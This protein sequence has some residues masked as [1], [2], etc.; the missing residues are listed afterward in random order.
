MFYEL[1]RKND[2]IM[3]LD[4]SETGDIAKRG[5]I[6]N[7]ELLPLQDRISHK[8]PI[9]WWNDRKIPIGQGKVDKMLRE[10]GILGTSEYLLLNLGLSLTDYYWIK[11]LKSDLT[12]EQVNLF[13]NDFKDDL[14][15]GNISNGN[16]P[17]TYTP[18]SSLQG[19]LEKTWIINNG[20]RYLVKG[21]YGSLSSESINETI[22]SDAFSK[23]G[24]D[25]L[26]Y[27]LIH[28]DGKPYTFGCISELFTSKKEELV[29]A[30][31]VVTSEIKKNDVSMYE[32]FINVCSLNGLDRDYVRHF[33]EVQIMMD[34]IFGNT[35]RHLTNIAVLR[36]ADTLKFT[37]LAP[38]FDSGKSLQAR[39]DIIKLSPKILL[40]E[41][42]NGFKKKQYDMLKLVNDRDS[43]S[44]NLL[45][46]L[47]E[48]EESYN[49]DELITEDRIKYILS[50]YEQKI[51]LFEKFQQ[52]K[53]MSAILFS[54][55]TKKTEAAGDETQKKGL[56][57]SSS[58]AAD[59]DSDDEPGR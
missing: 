19:N 24:L 25:S 58:A 55:I 47:S 53:D 29:S 56:S 30:Y 46:S 5:D 6:V 44:I 9:S 57:E 10:K 33:L 51:D 13:D 41:E 7:R 4:L 37:R 32:H 38:V 40:N 8:A 43:V 59:N 1:M 54:N 52:K 22:I 28:I 21:N 39:K 50:Y 23:Q 34:F 3:L 14:L 16:N 49:K 15:L 12:W 36:D 20:K 31:A 18:H 35:D 42:T 48:I 45:P 26:K 27:S 17:A 2:F 11:P